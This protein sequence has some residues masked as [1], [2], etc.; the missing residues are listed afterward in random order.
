[1][2]HTPKIT[3]LIEGLQM[4]K[5]FF[6][7]IITIILAIPAASLS[8]AEPLLLKSFSIIGRKAEPFKPNKKGFLVVVKL[9][10]E[11][12]LKGLVADF[13]TA[14]G[15]T[16]TVKGVIQESGVTA[17]N[18]YPLVEY[19]AD[20]GEG[21]KESYFVRVKIKP[22]FKMVIGGSFHPSYDAQYTMLNLGAD[23]NLM[24]GG[25][26]DRLT[27]GTEVSNNFFLFN[28]TYNNLD[29]SG[30]WNVLRGTV[31]FE[32]LVN[33]YLAFKW[34]IGS[35]WMYSVFQ[36]NEITL[37]E[38]NQPS[39]AAFLNAVIYPWKFLELEIVNRFDL[40]IELNRGNPFTTLDNFYPYYQGGVR[41]SLVQLVSWLKI[42]I[43]VSG[44]YTYYKT[45]VVNNSGAMLV[46]N[47]GVSFNLQFPKLI[48]QY[49]EKNARPD[50][51]EKVEANEEDQFVETAQ[52]LKKLEEAP[53]GEVINFWEI[54]FKKDS[55]ELE[56]GSLQILDEIARFMGGYKGIT[57]S[58][59]T[60]SEIKDD[61]LAS[62]NQSIERARTI[63]YYLLERGIDEKQ[64]KIPAQA[65]ILSAD[66][67]ASL[68]GS[69][70]KITVIKK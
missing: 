48:G 15:V 52:S 70:V 63:K 1:M 54:K 4:K 9:P 18:F 66:E 45:D 24:V 62:L 33:R 17:N 10:Y 47:T 43:E 12:D 39:F 11:R 19:V 38:R 51:A 31:N 6:I 35:S 69:I 68:R 28:G 30:Y 22:E 40:F 34:G 58:I 44:L 21:F 29:L 26:F 16:L 25:K 3:K 27:F 56:E 65:T 8:M 23:G 49:R 64:L 50:Q 7:I 53:L 59:Q 60:Y 5:T 46:I 20:N 57:I 41:V 2:Y 37:Y 13:E 36:Y 67:K 42:Y 55:I 61:P 32:V 14:E